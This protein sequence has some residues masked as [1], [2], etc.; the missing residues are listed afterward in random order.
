MAKTGRP[1]T[2]IDLDQAEKL[3]MLQCTYKECSAWLGIA[4]STLKSHKEFS[5]AFKKGKEKGKLSLRRSQFK[6]A[7]KNA[8]MAIWLGKNYLGQKD[9]D[10]DIIQQEDQDELFNKLKEVL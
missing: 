5:A 9:P 6:L 1:K 2:K 8:G 7:E 4:E 3:G 10:K